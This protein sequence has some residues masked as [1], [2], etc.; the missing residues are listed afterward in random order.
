MDVIFCLFCCGERDGYRLLDAA[1]YGDAASCQRLV[2]KTPKTVATAHQWGKAEWLS[3]VTFPGVV[4]ASRQARHDRSHAT[5]C[6]QRGCCGVH[7]VLS[8][9]STALLMMT[10]WLGSMTATRSY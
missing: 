8:Y 1:R 5:M 2:E 10:F 4:A 7:L 9:S 3:P 6:K